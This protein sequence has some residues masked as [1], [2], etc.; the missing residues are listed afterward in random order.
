MTVFLAAHREH[1]AE[2]R[3]IE[4]L[5][6][7]CLYH[8]VVY[9]ATKNDNEEQSAVR[10]R[11]DAQRL[12]LGPEQTEIVSI[13]IMATKKHQPVNDS[14]D[15]QVFLDADLAVLGSDRRVTGAI[16]SRFAASMRTSTEKRLPRRPH[17]GAEEIS[18][19]R[20]ALFQRNGARERTLKRRRRKNLE[21]TKFGLLETPRHV[22]SAV[23]TRNASGPHPDVRDQTKRNARNIY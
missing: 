8:D 20:A 5:L 22:S 7:A 18:H 21:A 6:F 23:S 12:G 4:N 11:V 10:W 9:D 16:S 17:R 2:I 19:P 14:F 15:M 3:N 13:L 1:R